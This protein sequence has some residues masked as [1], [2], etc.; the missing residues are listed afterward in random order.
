MTVVP[1]CAQPRSPRGW[2]WR[3]AAEMCGRRTRMPAD[4]DQQEFL[5]S[6]DSRVRLAPENSPTPTVAD[7]LHK[8]GTR[9]ADPMSTVSRCYSIALTDV[10]DLRHHDHASQL[11]PLI[12]LQ[13][14]NLPDSNGLDTRLRLETCV[15]SRE[16][17]C[18]FVVRIRG[19]MRTQHFRIRGSV[20][21]R[22]EQI[23]AVTDSVSEQQWSVRSISIWHCIVSYRIVSRYFVQ[24]C[25]VSIVFPHGHIVPSLAGTDHIHSN[26]YTN[27]H[28]IPTR[29]PPLDKQCRSAMV[30]STTVIYRLKEPE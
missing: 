4:A 7:H 11:Q 19:L 25:I 3:S 24:Y 22:P 8:L 26:S 13:C 28:D 30:I 1:A 6:A 2:P 21:F 29:R 17:G 10:F 15:G 18:G 20:R 5:R 12:V 9:Q 27:T 16:L 23:C 14:P